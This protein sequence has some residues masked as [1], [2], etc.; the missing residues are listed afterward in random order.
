MKAD[1]STWEQVR[2]D[3]AKGCSYKK[4]S[5]KYGIGKTTIVD[6]AKKEGWDADRKKLATAT[7][8]AMIHARERAYAHEAKSRS[9][10][11]RRVEDA[12]EKLASVLDKVCGEMDQQDPREMLL[13]PK[14]IGALASLAVAL[15]TNGEQLA[16]LYGIMDAYKKQQVEI[17]WE[18]LAME[19]ARE[20]AE[21]QTSD[22]PLFELKVETEGAPLDE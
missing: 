4:L 20:A 16:T 6:R 12:A 18:K 19:K 9:D 5:D 13:D 2:Q 11:M 22:A 17:A 10:R 7:G 3:F 15:K 21:K 8:T 14:R 1:E